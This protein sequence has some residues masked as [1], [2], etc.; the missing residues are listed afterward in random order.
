MNSSQSGGYILPTS[1]QKLPDRLTLMQ[2]I[3][4]VLVG[5]SG[6]PGTLVRPNWQV[7]PPKN[8][9]LSVNWL[10]FGI[11][12][13][14]PNANSWIG[15]D[16]S[17]NVQSQRHA[18]IEIQCSFYGPDSMDNADLVRDG[19]QIQQNLYALRSANMG[20]TNVGPANH[21]PDLVNERF[22]DRVQ[23]SIFLQREVQRYYPI[24]T[25]VSANGTITAVSGDEQYLLDWQTQT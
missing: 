15:V 20:F 21:I 9:D 14:T 10:A 24:S 8:P 5:V 16:S 17:G 2:F 7:A 1:T 12:N 23:M 22:I 4:T 25:L 18:S 19:F 11:V 13:G 6:L 3:N